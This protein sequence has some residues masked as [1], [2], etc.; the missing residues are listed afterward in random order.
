V[1]WAKFTN[2]QT[3][4]SDKILL[5]NKWF[6]GNKPFVAYKLS[7]SLGKASCS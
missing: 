1:Y 5:V 6:V 4:A 3:S 2:L 7:L